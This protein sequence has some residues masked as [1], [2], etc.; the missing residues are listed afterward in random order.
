MR[1]LVRSAPLL[2]VCGVMLMGCGKPGD[3]GSTQ[4]VEANQVLLKVD[5]LH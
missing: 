4:K 3:D 2:L 5:G 1:V